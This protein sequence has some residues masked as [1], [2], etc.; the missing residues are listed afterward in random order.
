MAAPPIKMA[1]GKNGT[2]FDLGDG[3][4]E[5]VFAPDTEAKTIEREALTAQLAFE[6]GLPTPKI[7]DVQTH[8]IRGWIRSQKIEG[9]ALSFF[10]LKRPWKV[11]WASREMAKCMVKIHA[12]SDEQIRDLQLE[13]IGQIEKASWSRAKDVW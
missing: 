7:L 2:V 9:E 3:S 4:V 1:E 13:L 5:K 12:V 6:Y 11:I 10:V 8:G